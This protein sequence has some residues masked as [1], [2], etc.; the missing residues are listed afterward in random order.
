MTD[1][2]QG[3]LPDAAAVERRIRSR[4]AAIMRT[5]IHLYFDFLKLILRSK[6]F[7]VGRENVESLQT[8]FILASNHTGHAD[9]HC[10]LRV[11]PPEIA[12]RTAVAAAPRFPEG[13]AAASAEEEAAR[14]HR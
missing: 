9:T 7:A 1:A 6:W 5:V 4:R 11:L 10:I 2:E 8:P 3:A 12:K 13:A 14:T